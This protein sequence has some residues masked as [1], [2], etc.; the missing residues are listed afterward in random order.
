LGWAAEGSFEKDLEATVQWYIDNL[1]WVNTKL[2]ML[3]N[4]WEKIYGP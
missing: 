4:Y 3:K 2:H 1:G